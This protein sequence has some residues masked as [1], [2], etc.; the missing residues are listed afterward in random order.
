MRVKLPHRLTKDEVRER[1][2]DHAHEIGG[3]VAA[4]I[5]TSWADPDHLNL[6]VNAMGQELT[7]AISIGDGEITVE[8]DLPFMLS[9][10]EPMIAGAIREKGQALLA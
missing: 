2:R 4:Q 1:L 5:D 9:F 10:A 7:G 3:K 6:S 8:L